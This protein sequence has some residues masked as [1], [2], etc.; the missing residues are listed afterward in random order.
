MEVYTG[1]MA[2]NVLCKC[3]GIKISRCSSKP[4]ERMTKTKANLCSLMPC[5]VS[6]MHGKIVSAANY[7][8]TPNSEDN[9]IYIKWTRR[10]TGIVKGHG[11]HDLTEIPLFGSL[12]IE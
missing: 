12:N 2:L 4:M 3:E 5:A 8:E 6:D 9:H 10:H 11:D 7:H 1:A